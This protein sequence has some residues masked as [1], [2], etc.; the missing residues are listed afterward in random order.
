LKGDKGSKAQ[1][2]WA[3]QMCQTQLTWVCEGSLLLLLLS[4]LLKQF[5]KKKLLLLEKKT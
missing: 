5:E 3:W 1:V 4:L 2:N